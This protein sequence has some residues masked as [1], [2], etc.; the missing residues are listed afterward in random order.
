MVYVAVLSSVSFTV[1]VIVEKPKVL[2]IIFNNLSPLAPVRTKFELE[3]TASL[4]LFT[5]TVKSDNAVL[6]SEIKKGIPMVL[7]GSVVSF[8]TPLTKPAFVSDTSKNDVKLAVSTTIFIVEAAT[9][10]K[11]PGDP[12]ADSPSLFT[13]VAAGTNGPSPRILKLPLVTS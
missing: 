3:T 4:L 13:A 5:K 9:F 2:G 6:E 7:A 10:S 11:L 1:I 12:I 8:T